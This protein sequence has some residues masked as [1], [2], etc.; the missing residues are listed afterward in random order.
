MYGAA[1]ETPVE[2]E[3]V[4][5]AGHGSRGGSATRYIVAALLVVAAIAYFMYRPGP[6]LTF[7]A[8][9]AAWSKSWNDSV[10]R[11]QSTRKP[12]LV[13]YTADWC[14][15]CRWFESNVLVR[16][17]V[18]SYMESRYTPIMVDLTRPDSPNQAF[19]RQYKIDVIPTLVLYNADGRELSRTNVLPPEQLLAWLRSDGRSTK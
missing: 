13:L 11:S 12:A 10:R 8:E 19:A 9:D 1:P 2:Q 7:A 3:P 18:R 15:A 16:G 6:T 5:S 17:D 4:Q 14:P